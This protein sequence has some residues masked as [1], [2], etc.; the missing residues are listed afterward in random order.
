MEN[1]KTLGEYICQ[2]RKALGLTQQEFA[3]KLFVTNSA[4]SKW[5]RGLSYPDITLIHDICGILQISEHELLTASEDVEARSAERLAKKYLRLARNYR[6]A[7]YL[8]YGGAAAVCLIVDLCD[9][10][11]FG[12]SLIV[13]ASLLLAASLTLAPALAPERM[14]LVCVCGAFT[15]SLLLLLGASAAYTGGSWFPT[16]ACGVLLG[17]GALFLPFVLRRLPLPP[18]LAHRKSLLYFAAETALLILLLAAIRLTTSPGHWLLTAILGT[19]LGESAVLLPLLMRQLPLPAELRRHKAAV[20]LGIVAVLLVAL[21]GWARHLSGSD[22]F[23]TFDV[24]LTLICLALP[25]ALLLCLRYLPVNRYYRASLS[26]LAAALWVWVAPWGVDRVMLADGWQASN[27]YEL[28]H[29]YSV[30]F[31]DWVSAPTAGGNVMV[32]ILA[33]LLVAAVALGLLGRLLPRDKS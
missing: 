32:L 30:D 17:L 28:L 9:G 4:V 19:L 16:A 31:S 24:P 20:W 23:F 22:N 18:A 21:L 29:P 1:K 3:D 11:A 33:A 26:C 13:L 12:W 15:V 14:G 5:E 10:G 25:L 2:R 7:Q 27:H 8:L 6:L